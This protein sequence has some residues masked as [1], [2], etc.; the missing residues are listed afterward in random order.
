MEKTE[1][2]ELYRNVEMFID[3]KH[4][5]GTNRADRKITKPHSKTLDEHFPWKGLAG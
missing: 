5:L 2:G 3:E 4:L 1:F